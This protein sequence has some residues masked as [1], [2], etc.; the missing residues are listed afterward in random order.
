MVQ[1]HEHGCRVH[2]DVLHPNFS[3]EGK[4]IVWSRLIE[5][6]STEHPFVR[7]N[8]MVADFVVAGERPAS[9]TSGIS[10]LKVEFS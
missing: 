5:R 3:Q 6:T 8:L 4:K 7:W 2:D 9:R 10:P 1:A